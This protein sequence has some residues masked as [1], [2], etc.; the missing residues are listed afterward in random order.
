[1][2]FPIT[3]EEL[4]SYRTRNRKEE[5]INVYVVD[6]VNEICKKVQRSAMAF[7]QVDR[8]VYPTEKSQFFVDGVNI[9]SRVIDTLKKRFPDC[10]IT[11]DENMKYLIIDWS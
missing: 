3:R 7:Y 8:C 10:D 11:I 1:M 4:Q 6:L 2:Q 9:F 5:D